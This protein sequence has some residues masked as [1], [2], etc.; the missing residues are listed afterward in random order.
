MN[1]KNDKTSLQLFIVAKETVEENLT[2]L[3]LLKGRKIEN[4]TMSIVLL[5]EER[6]RMRIVLIFEEKEREL[7][8]LL[9]SFLLPMK[10]PGAIF[11]ML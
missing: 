10:C 9:S 3:P 7:L 11:E 6:D 2:F 4:K 1:R 5:F 8:F